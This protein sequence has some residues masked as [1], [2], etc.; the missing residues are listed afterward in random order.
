MRPS[1]PSVRVLFVVLFALT[2]VLIPASAHAATYTVGTTN[3]DHAKCGGVRGSGGLD[4]AGN[5]YLPC[6]YT[7]TGAAQPNI[8]VYDANDNLVKDIIVPVLTPTAVDSYL[9]DVA[10][11]PDGQ[12]LY[13]SEYQTSKFFRLVRRADGSY[14]RDDTF[15]LQKYAYG[16]LRTP[17]GQYLA[18]DGLGNV[19]ISNGT[20]VTG[21]PAL[22]LKYNAQGQLLTT[23]GEY[24]QTWDLGKFYWILGGLTV[25]RDGT[26][27]WTAENGNS[28]VQEWDANG[29]GSYTAV[30]A[31]GSSALSDPNRQG[32]CGR[33]DQLAAPYDIASDMYDNV[34]VINTSCGSINLTEVHRIHGDQHDIIK[35]VKFGADRQHA[36]AVTARGTIFEP[37]V[38]AVL[39]AAPGRYEGAPQPPADRTAPAIQA[40]GVPNRTT[41]SIFPIDLIATD[42]VGVTQMRLV[43]GDGD[44]AAAPWVAYNQFANQGSIDG[45]DGTYRVRAQV[46]DAA[47]NVSPIAESQVVYQRVVADAVAPAIQAVTTPANS[48]IRLIP[49]DVTATDNVGVAQMRIVQG[50]AD[51]NA[52]PWVAYNQFANQ[53]TLAG[54]NGDKLISVQVRDAAGNVSAV[55]TS[56]TMLAVPPVPV[57]DVTAPVLSQVV[58]PN[59][60]AYRQV[61]LAVTATDNVAVAEMRFATEDGNWGAWQQFS[62]APTFTLKAGAGAH[63]VFVQVRDAKGN[64]SNS[65]YRT[66]ISSGLEVPAGGGGDPAPNPDPDP[67]PVPAGPDAAPVLRNVTLPAT[68]ATQ[69]VV[70]TIDATDDKAV[71]EV[72]FA[73]ESGIW[74]AWQPFAA[75]PTF[76]LTA[77]AGARGVF[78]QV[79]DIKRQESGTIYRTTTLA[80]NA[81]A[82]I[83]DPIPNPDPNPG[84][85]DAA[86]P[87][88]R[89][90][91]LPATTTSRLITVAIDATDDIGVT[92]VRL[93][94]E[95]GVWGAWQNFA[96]RTPWVLT[97]V[98]MTKGVFVQVRDAAH[99]ESNI[100]YR[101]TLCG[102]PCS[103]PP[104]GALMA[105]HRA[106]AKAKHRAVKLRLRRGSMRADKVK[107]ARSNDDYDMSQQDGKRDVIDCGA[108]KRDT[109]L[110]RPEDVTRH[111][112]IV[113]VVRNPR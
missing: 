10:P 57:N 80:P 16:G 94:N 106:T 67:D 35:G 62:A 87:I 107:G 111:C 89:A 55:A 112:E 47:G 3:F 1:F 37:C 36:I 17:R 63:G 8:R 104:A 31:Y 4:N 40:L 90:V 103:D 84:A 64:E 95:T 49:V 75:A 99:K 45:G 29:V 50:N 11:S 42:N 83:P 54:D 93:A 91:T 18:T 9:A 105:K 59:P 26:Q 21:E 12:Y 58:V 30:R 33:I 22:V 85:V 25:S 77:G 109:V 6:Y 53:L 88:V 65:L 101:T 86:A 92:Q 79:R 113:R 78:V 73:T 28:R 71:T 81:P 2:C 34:Y 51:I 15:T 43:I 82:P 5:L 70:V 38:N 60:A 66:T 61:V 14:A 110:K 7:P 98:A 13:V 72:R 96:A 46:R 24:A 100:L 108:G 56:H 32:G 20:W 69:N 44:I 48:T 102:A 41:I 76:M 68:T 74:G 52:A 39:A 23:F 19:Y 27:V 97:K